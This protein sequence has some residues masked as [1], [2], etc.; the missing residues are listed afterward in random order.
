M[1]YNV[2]GIRRFAAVQERVEQFQQPQNVALIFCADIGVA[3]AALRGSTAYTVCC[4]T[5]ELSLKAIIPLTLYAFT[6]TKIISKKPEKLW[7]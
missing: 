3:Q 4:T 7:Y 6:H 5:L 2:Q 1:V